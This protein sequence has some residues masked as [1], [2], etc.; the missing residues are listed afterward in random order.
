MCGISGIINLSENSKYLQNKEKIELM[1][2]SINHRGPDSKNFWTSE[3]KKIFFGH[4]RLSIQDLSAKASQPMVSATG[5]Y[6][7]VYNGEI[8]NHEE[9]R[10]KINNYKKIIWK[11]LSD[12][13]S[14]IN[15]IEIF[16]LDDFCQKAKGM[17]AFALFDKKKNK[18]FLVRDRFGEKPLYY[19]YFD[20]QLVFSSE[21]R[22][23]MK[24]Y[25]NLELNVSSIKYFLQLSYIPAPQT[26]FKKINKLN[27]ASILEL[28][29]NNKISNH[30]LYKW[31][32]VEDEI[33]KSKKKLILDQN[34]AIVEFEKKIFRVVKE[35]L[36]SD[37]PVGCFLSGGID[38]TIIAHTMSHLSRNKIETFSIGFNNFDYDESLISQKTSKNLRTNHN[39]LIIE[40]KDCSKVIENI[41]EY[42]DE[43]F[44]DSSQIPTV[45][46]SKFAKKKVTVCLTGDGGDEVFAGYNRYFMIE[47]IWNIVSKFPYIS[48]KYLCSILEQFPDRVLKK[49][50][51]YFAG[52]KSLLG[53]KIKKTLSAIRRSRNIDDFYKNILTVINSEL[54]I[55]ERFFFN[56]PDKNYYFSEKEKMMVNDYK[57]Y[58]PDDILCKVDRA[59][60]AS[61]LET[62]IPFLDIDIFKFAWTLPMNMKISKN[63][64]KIFLKNYLKKV[65]PEYSTDQAKKGFSIPISSWLRND[66]KYLIEEILLSNKI[67]NLEIFD[68][69]K[70]IKLWQE[71]KLN[72]NSLSGNLFWNIYVLFSWIEKYKKSI[73]IL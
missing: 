38:S 29:L 58:L 30:N 5:R 69:N 59:S 56:S 23:F 65:F 66:Y 46:I 19:G 6:V 57:N 43:P 61:S 12:T 14:L 34:K 41:S 25:S 39:E 63:S 15:Y 70:I 1:T 2:N 11:S 10:I 51:I 3:C 62:R 53:E 55:N 44:A 49:I 52:E 7:I 27:Q 32:S 33:H 72:K 21:L 35:Q 9:L 48:R 67:K 8:Y 45:L 4:N 28:D 16:G 60:M 18:I 50:I 54:L 31:W 42:Y 64:Q 37:V 71:F 17:F 20:D 26:I 47:K 40:S 36:I 73:K 13:E 22:P 68:Q 24:I